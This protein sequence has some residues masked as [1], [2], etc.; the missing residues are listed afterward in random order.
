[1]HYYLE[2]SVFVWALL[3]E[4]RNKQIFKVEIEN[5]NVLKGGIEICYANPKNIVV[6]ICILG[7]QRIPIVQ[8]WLWLS[9]DLEKIIEKYCRWDVFEYSITD[10]SNGNDGIKYHGFLKRIIEPRFDSQSP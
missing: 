8:L 4:T 6:N 10:Y 5:K 3:R 7:N 1:M 2:N 9:L